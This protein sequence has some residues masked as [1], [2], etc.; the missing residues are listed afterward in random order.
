MIRQQQSRTLN[1]GEFSSTASVRMHM[2]R[3]DTR[4]YSFAVGHHWA[5]QAWVIHGIRC[6]TVLQGTV[7]LKPH[8]ST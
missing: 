7:R 3:R 1:L 8:D 6:N 5:S 4:I 2:T